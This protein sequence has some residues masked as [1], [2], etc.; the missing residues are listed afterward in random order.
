MAEHEPVPSDR[1]HIRRELDGAIT[2]HLTLRDE[3]AQ[4][5]YSH[6]AAQRGAVAQ[7]MEPIFAFALDCISMGKSAIT[8]EL[9]ES[10]H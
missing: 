1:D 6:P 5:V 4:T 7:V 9:V 2:A 10:L 3:I 8:L